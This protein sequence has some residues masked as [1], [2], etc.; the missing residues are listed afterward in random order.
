MVRE[1]TNASI[2]A[3]I[4]FVWVSAA[5]FGLV[6][7]R[8]VEIF[9]SVVASVAVIALGALFFGWAHCIRTHFGYVAVWNASAVFFVRLVVKKAFLWIVLAWVLAWLRFKHVQ[10]EELNN[11]IVV[12]ARIFHLY[13][14]KIKCFTIFC[15]MIF[16]KLIKIYIRH[17]FKNRI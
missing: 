1:C 2:F 16:F 5:K 3:L 6:L 12:K 13:L 10:V 8:V 15:F 4:Y 7:L 14:I 17:H 9:N 11:S